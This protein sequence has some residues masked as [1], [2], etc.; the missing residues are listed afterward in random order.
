MLIIEGGT[1]SGGSVIAG[2]RGFGLGSSQNGRALGSGIFIQ[3]GQSISLSPASGST[4][5][6]SDV[7]T[8]QAGS[9]GS[10]A[11][12]LSLLGVGTVALSAANRYTGGT[13]VGAT[14]TLDLAARGAAGS[15]PITLAADA[16]ATLRIEIAAFTDDVFATPVSGFDRND[17][18]DLPGLAYI[19]GSTATAFAGGQLTVT[20]DIVT[21]TLSNL[22]GIADGT[23]F[24][25]SKDA[26]GGTTVTAP[27]C[28]A[29]GTRI[30]TVNGEVPVEMLRV[31]DTVVT[32]RRGTRHIRCNGIGQGLAARVRHRA[33][34]PAI[35]RK[36]T[37]GETVPH[38]D[39]CRRSRNAAACAT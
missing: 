32:P 34:T 15:G 4:L 37:L 36:G 27:L 35:T 3:G 18:I 33:A 8:D 26:S 25:T 22:S 12:S 31:G 20:N 38:N 24:Q 39:V 16:A 13:S 6:I 7:I 23:Q 21:V 1:L 2:D 11:G 28:F 30:L 10:G 17:L 14:G 29:E 19:A 5:S 9:G